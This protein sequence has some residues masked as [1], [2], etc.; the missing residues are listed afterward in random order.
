MRP[1]SQ[2]A[3]RDKMGIVVGFVTPFVFTGQPPPGDW[4]KPIKMAVVQWPGRKKL[5][6][7]PADGLLSPDDV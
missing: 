7:E 2:V 4:P 6:L 3:R 1:G 5:T